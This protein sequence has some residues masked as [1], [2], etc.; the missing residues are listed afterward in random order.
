MTHEYIGTK[1]V[2]AWREERDGKPGYAVKYADGYTSWSPRDVFEEAYIDI[3]HVSH[4]PPHQQRMIGEKVELDSKLEKLNKFMQGVVFAA[5]ALHDRTLMTDQYN[6][7]L[8]YSHAL[9]KRI[10]AAGLY[11]ANIPEVQP[12]ADDVLHAAPLNSEAARWK[13]A[14]ENMRDWA[15]SN[16]LDV[17]CY[18]VGKPAHD[19]DC[20]QHNEPSMPAGPCDCSASDAIE[21]EIR[22]KGLTAPRIT[23]AQIDALMSRVHF[24][25]VR[26]P[27]DTTSTFVHAFLD[28]KF[29]LGTGFS[30]C[31]SPENFDAEVGRKIATGKAEQIARDKL[32]ELE[33]YALYRNLQGGAA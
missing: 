2:T 16:G 13:E 29:L 23:P 22:A 14:Y 8:N 15:I 9:G 24:V 6:A 26:Q 1:I 12:K 3:G 5:L 18:N 17:R 4:L 31:V 25:M 27:G 7:M 20:A 11:N 19:S 32:W 33:G 10:D 30:A 28:G 21:Q